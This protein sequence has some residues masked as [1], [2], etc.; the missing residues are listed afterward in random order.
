MLWQNKCTVYS[1]DLYRDS[2]EQYKPI[3]W[4]GFKAKILASA[5]TE[6]KILSSTS[7]VWPLP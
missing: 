3:V 1:I 4:L 6:A 5:G 7:K 2:K